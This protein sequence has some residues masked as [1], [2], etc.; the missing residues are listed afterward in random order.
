MYAGGLRGARQSASRQEQFGVPEEWQ[1]VDGTVRHLRRRGGRLMLVTRA[2]RH[3]LAALNVGLGLFLGGAVAAPILARLGATQAADALYAAYKLTCHQW[4]FRSFF[5]FGQQPIYSVQELADNSLDPFTFQGT[6]A[7]GWKMAFC[8]RDLAIYIGLLLVGI[9]FARRRAVQPCGFVLYGVLILPMAIDGFTQLFVGAKAPG[10]SVWRPG[11]CS[12]SPAP[13]WCCPPGCRI[14][15]RAAIQPVCSSHQHRMRT[16]V[17]RPVAA[18]VSATPDLLDWLRGLVS[19]AFVLL[20]PMLIIAPA[21]R[22]LVTDRDF[23]LRGFRE[24]QVARTTGLTIRELERVADAF[25][26]YFQ[27]PRGQIQMQVIAFGQPRQL[28]DEKEVTHM[29]DV[30][31]LI[32]WFSAFPADR[33][34]SRRRQTCIRGGLR[35]RGGVPRP[36]TAVEHRAD[37][38]AGRAG[39]RSLPDGLRRAVD[40]LSP[41]CVPK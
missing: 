16:T 40:A 2:L 29:E 25:V 19:L 27:G 41:D 32:Q 39:R 35:S 30:Q 34:R 5:L 22:G 15:P 14:W 13:G 4:A 28:F 18:R 38:R 24:N 6:Q 1:L 31:A 17:R 21:W 26:A 37:G 9:F 12:D 11:S 10:S 36:R 7:F 23:M 3:W 20:V 8:E 33:G